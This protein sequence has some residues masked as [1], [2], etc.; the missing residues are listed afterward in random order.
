MKTQKKLKK[1]R[2][3]HHKQDKGAL[4]RLRGLESDNHSWQAGGTAETK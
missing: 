2:K 3:K 1:K 4:K